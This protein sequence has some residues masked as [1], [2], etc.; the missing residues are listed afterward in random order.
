MTLE[1]HANSTYVEHDW[2]S[3]TPNATHSAITHFP[4]SIIVIRNDLGESL[5]LEGT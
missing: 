3:D 2:D 4:S 1:E 5:I